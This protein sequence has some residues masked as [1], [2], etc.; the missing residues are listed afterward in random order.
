MV[1]TWFGYL[2]RYIH[3][4]DLVRARPLRHRLQTVPEHCVASV[5]GVDNED[6]S[7]YLADARERLDPDYGTPC[8][9]TVTLD[10]P[11]GP[12]TVRCFAPVTGGWS[13]SMP[14]EGGRATSVDL[15]PF[16]H[17]LVVRISRKD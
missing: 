12:Y 11:E 3:E 5:F 16:E 17:D 9:G 1:R 7:I 13:P 8:A 15:P 2:S 4:L 14:I 6:L 10:L